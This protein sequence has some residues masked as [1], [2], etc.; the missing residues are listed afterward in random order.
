MFTVDIR[1][2]CSIHKERFGLGWVVE[3]PSTPRGKKK[4]VL[5]A[6]REDEERQ[7]SKACPDVKG[8]WACPKDKREGKMQNKG[9]LKWV[10]LYAVSTHPKASASAPRAPFGVT[11]HARP[12]FLRLLWNTEPKQWLRANERPGSSTLF[13][14]RDSR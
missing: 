4:K 1:L 10:A 2:I 5:S 13:H 14:R 7:C 11:D 3:V 9:K 8:G 12:P 6:I